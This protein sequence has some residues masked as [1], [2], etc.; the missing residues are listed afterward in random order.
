MLCDKYIY[1]NAVIKYSNQILALVFLTFTQLFLLVTVYL[2]IVLF[3]HC[4]YLTAL[5]TL[6]I[7]KGK[8]DFK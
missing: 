2:T 4:M 3:P 7:T 8:V 5:V 6:Q 1:S